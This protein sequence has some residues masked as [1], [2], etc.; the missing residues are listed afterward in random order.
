MTLT[1]QPPIQLVDIVKFSNNR[2]YALSK[3]N[4]TTFSNY[5]PYDRGA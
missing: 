1:H 4:I 5:S 2:Q 3:P